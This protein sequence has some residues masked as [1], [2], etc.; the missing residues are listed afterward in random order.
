MSE[1]PLRLR[2]IWHA[3]GSTPLSLQVVL[4]VLAGTILGAASGTDPFIKGT[5]FSTQQLGQL[6]NLVIQILKLLA[7]VLVFFAIIDAFLRTAFTAQQG[8]RLVFFCFMNVAVAMLIGLTIMNVF[9]PGKHWVGQFPRLENE[10]Q[11]IGDARKLLQYTDGADGAKY[12]DPLS[13][14]I[15]YFPTNLLQPFQENNVLGVAMIA[16][17]LGAALRAV[18]REQI[19][20]STPRA[21]TRGRPAEANAL[22][23]VPTVE[24]FATIYAA[25]VR[26]V[27]WVVRL[28]PLAI[29]FLLAKVVG[30]EGVWVFKD[31]WVLLLT[32]S[33]G[34]LLHGFVY[35]PLVAWVIGGRSPIVFLGYGADAILTAFSS[36]SSMATVP[37]TLRCLEKMGVSPDAARLSACVGTNL[38]NDGI[39]L[40]DAMTALFLLQALSQDVGIGQQ[41]S[42]VLASIMAGAG[43]A[44]IPEAGLI[45]LPLVLGAAGLP[46]EVIVQVIPL[47]MVIDWFVA[48][49][50]SAINTMNDMLI[51]ILVDATTTR[52]AAT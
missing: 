26:M 13:N 17:I 12:L 52:S 9:R 18:V 32:L 6:G 33:A 25:C 35:Y 3:L 30:R 49:L 4:A 7:V 16:V 42:I 1:A 34:L 45:V 41:V 48:R 38:N 2:S 27:E 8:L 31:L 43:I 40:Y 10:M 21:G 22:P 51:A 20:A 11:R 50:R 23:P 46:A 44:G 39:T 5:S 19:E 36:N 14:F 47:V 15:R 29:F 24:V 28:V 37:V